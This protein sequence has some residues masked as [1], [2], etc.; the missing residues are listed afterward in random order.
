MSNTYNLT[1]SKQKEAENYLKKLSIQSNMPEQ[2][3]EKTLMF[4]AYIDYLEKR[5]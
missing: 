4:K 3:A 5:E 1:K 2:E